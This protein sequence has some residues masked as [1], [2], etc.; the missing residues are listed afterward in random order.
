V[1]QSSK[2]KRRYNSTRRQA[3]ADETRRQIID[4]ADKLFSMYGYSGATIDS[5]AQAAAVS[6]ETVYAIFGNKRNILTSLI[7][8]TV[9]GDNRPIPLLQRAGPQA[10]LQEN[11]PQRLLRLFAQDISGILERVAPIMEIIRAAAK[12]E[13]EIAD[14]LKNLLNQRFQNLASVIKH[15]ETLG[16]LREGIDELQATESIWVI[17]SPEVYSLLLTDRGWTNG[18]YVDW[19]SD[20]LVRILLT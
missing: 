3:Q 10:V 5:I 13:P 8:I 6:S 20:T 19:L 9:G 7:D 15:L 2:S 12:T 1:T 18:R 16:S 17:T 11:D 14:L 4:S